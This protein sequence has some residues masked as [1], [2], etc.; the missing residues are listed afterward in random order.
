MSTSTTTST[1]SRALELLG[2]GVEPA[3]VA[4]TLGISV[5]RISQLLSQ[6][7]FA[8]KVTELRY[9]NL[10]KHN[11][12]DASLDELEDKLIKKMQDVIPFMMRP[13][14]I[15]RALSVVNA[16]KRRGSSAPAQLVQAQTVINLNLPAALIN[17]FQLNINN[18]VTKAG[19][20][21]LLTIQSGT[22]LNTLKESQNEH[23]TAAFAERVG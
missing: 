22:L 2:N 19:Q 5:S 13:M 23:P 3:H 20:Q 14:E 21:D 18:Q 16:A 4:N 8:A 15:V 6:E 9:E 11:S 12:R 17:K 1:E 10:A 7:D